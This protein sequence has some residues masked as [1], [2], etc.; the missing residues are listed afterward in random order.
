MIPD[1]QFQNVQRRRLYGA[2]CGQLP[3]ADIDEGERQGV[4]ALRQVRVPAAQVVH[5]RHRVYLQSLDEE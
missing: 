5:D 2:F 1:S 4:P 3:G